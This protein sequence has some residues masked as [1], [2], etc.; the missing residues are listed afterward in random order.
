MLGYTHAAS[1]AV[2]W[3]AVAPPVAAAVGQP[4]P[5][6]AVAAGTFATAGAALL[7]DLDHPKATVAHTFGQVSHSVSKFVELASGG[8]RQGTHSFLFAAAAGAA[9]WAAVAAAGTP[10]ALAIL[11]IFTAFALRGL[12]LYPPK[13]HGATKTFTVIVEAAAATWAF[14]YLNVT[15]WWWLGPAVALGCLL[16][17]TGDCCT[18]ERCPLLW[19]KSRATASPSSP[20]PVTGPKPGSSRPH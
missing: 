3:L 1:G 12:K 19:P 4:L 14:N 16:H 18:P 7:P 17:L 15:D 11:F 9:T 5:L 6:A 10:A 20:T 8:H 13:M 2:G